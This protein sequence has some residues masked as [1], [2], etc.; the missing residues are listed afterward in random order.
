LV[1]EEVSTLARVEDEAARIV[2]EAQS[3][4]VVARVIGGLAVRAHCPSTNHASL[5]RIY[6]DID[7]VVGRSQAQRLE[8]LVESLGYVSNRAFNTL[9]GDRRQ[10]YHDEA[11]G[12]Q[13]DVFVGDF[14]MAHRIPMSRRLNVEPLT[15]PLAELF[16]SKAQI[17]ELNPK[18]VL[19][20]MALFLDHA[21]GDGDGETINLGIVSERCASDWG[22]FTT[23]LMTLDRLN[24]VLDRDG[25]AL[26]D[27]QKATVRQRV[28]VVR[29]ALEARPKTLAWKMRAR[30][31]RR[32]RWYQEV[33][34]VQR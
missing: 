18:D 6:P 17:V 10:L 3:R 23:V 2:A 21:V 32:V 13:I 16:L 30:L 15:V 27:R 20:L 19:D 31:G 5:E 33:E 9:N 1:A 22:L 25:V 7:L 14:D 8:T 34:E 28:R 12:R 4:G 24:H 11:R 29:D 26:D